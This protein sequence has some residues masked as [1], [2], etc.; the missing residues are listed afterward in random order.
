MTRKTVPDVPDGMQKIY[1]RF[2]RW[3]SSHQGRSPIPKALWAS[4]AEVAL[5]HGVFRT[6]TILRLEYAKLKRMT[7]S[8][9]P[10]KRRAASPAEFLELVAPHVAPLWVR[11][12]RVRYRAGRAARQDS[13]PVERRSGA[14][15]RWIEPRRVGVGVIQI[16]PQ[17]RILVAIEP[18]D[19]RKGID[20]LARLCQ[21]KLQADPFSGCLFVFRGCDGALPATRWPRTFLAAWHVTYRRIGNASTGIRSIIWR[22]SSTRSGFAGP[23][24]VRRTGWCWG[25]P[26]GAAKTIRQIGRS[27]KCLGFHSPG[28]FASYCNRC[29]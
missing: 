27:K 3:R 17:M 28:G 18:V 26:R 12:D 29:K 10:V 25:E 11:S 22:H 7:K 21:D 15:S 24:I 13:R 2:K 20:S 14:G 23:V 9:A 4:A 1:R 19:G 5:E 6:A 16:A 8:A